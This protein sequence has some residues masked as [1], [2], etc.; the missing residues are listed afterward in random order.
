[1]EKLQVAMKLPSK[2][3]QCSLGKQMGRW[4]DW[5]YSIWLPLDPAMAY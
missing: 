5:E 1:M 2:E 3:Y 4:L